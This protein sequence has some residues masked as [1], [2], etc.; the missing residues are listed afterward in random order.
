MG[1]NAMAQGTQGA[2]KE[3]QY[4]GDT[5]TG[6]DREINWPIGPDSFPHLLASPHPPD[7]ERAVK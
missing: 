6:G 3:I 4:K 2:K 7:M 1:I 5:G